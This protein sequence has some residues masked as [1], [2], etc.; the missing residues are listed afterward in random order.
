M[1]T[2]AWI[3]LI[4]QNRRTILKLTKGAFSTYRAARKKVRSRSDAVH[5]QMVD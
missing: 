2:R 1:N 4:V 3:K 5:V